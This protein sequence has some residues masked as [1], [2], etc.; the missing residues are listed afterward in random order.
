MKH[1]VRS[2]VD[3]EQGACCVAMCACLSVSYNSFVGGQ[4]L[5]ELCD[6]S[7][8]PPQFSPSLSQWAALFDVCAGAVAISQFPQ[9][10]DGF[11]RILI[12][13]E[14]RKTVHLPSAGQPDRIAIALLDLAMISRGEL[15]Q[16]VLGG[17]ID[18]AWLG[19]VAEW[20]LSL[21]VEICDPSGTCVYRSTS[22]FTH[23][24]TT[25]SNPGH[26]FR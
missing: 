18:C 6:S 15:Q 26:G 12:P 21:R 2:L 25:P 5:K 7:R 16:V 13:P 10:V 14:L 3:T 20:L 9:K 22:T 23:N 1:I 11:N 19:A 24:I 4:I 17:S 8:V